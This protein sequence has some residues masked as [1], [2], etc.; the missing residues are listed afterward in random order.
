[1]AHS[2]YKFE[3]KRDSSE[4]LLCKASISGSDIQALKSAIEDL[5]YFE[6]VLDDLPIR[7]FVGH[8]EEGGIA[9]L[10]EHKVRVMSGMKAI[11]SSP[12][13]VGLGVGSNVNFIK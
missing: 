8:F 13:C 7:G 12:L 10:H 2:M 5:Y 6:F 3:F 11:P 9:P 4:V 1:M